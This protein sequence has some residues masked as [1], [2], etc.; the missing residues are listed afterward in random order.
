[1]DGII[2]NCVKFAFPAWEVDGHAT[3]KAKLIG[4]HI[5]SEVSIVLIVILMDDACSVLETCLPTRLGY[6]E[7]LVNM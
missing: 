1:M 2:K 5:E 4:N 3:G 6:F 7:H